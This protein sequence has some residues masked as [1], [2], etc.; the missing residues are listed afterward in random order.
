MGQGFKTFFG[1]EWHA[2]VFCA[3]TALSFALLIASFIV[4]PTGVI[5]SSVLA[6]VGE[7]FAFAA[8]GEVSAAI[9]RGGKA[10]I[11]HG[12]TSVT[13][14]G[15]DDEPALPAPKEDNID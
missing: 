5:H 3:C 13:V 7:L 12:N 8:L 15:D 6:A 11:T 1:G 4:P 9:A 10:R 14:S 2:I